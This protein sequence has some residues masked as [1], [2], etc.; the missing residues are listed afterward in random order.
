MEAS[1]GKEKVLGGLCD[2]VTE[3]M[4]AL[5]ICMPGRAIISCSFWDSRLF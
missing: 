5:S 1:F 4:M 3:F 2:V